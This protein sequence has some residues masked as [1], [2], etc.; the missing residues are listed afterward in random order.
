MNIQE[1]LAYLRQTVARID[2]KYAG[3]PAVSAKP[4]VF[5]EELLS[6]EVIETPH[7][8]HFETEK[9]YPNHQRHGSYEISDLIGLQPDL[10]EALSDG[11]ITNAH[12]KR[13]AFLDTETTGLAGGSGTY[14]FLIGLG[15]IDEEGFRV[16][17]FFM[18]DYAEEASVLHSLAA[19]LARFDVL[20][21]YNG[22]SYDQ[23]LLETRYTMCRA[24]HPFA[25][26]E[27]LDLLYGARRLFKL[28]LESCRL[29]NLENQI[30]GVERTGDIPGEMIPY[31]FFE[32][33]RT[34][35]AHRLMPVF[36]HNV[37]DI[38]SLACL[39]GIIPEAFRDPANMRARHGMDLLGLARWLELSGRREEALNLMR[40]AIDMG[41]PDAQLFRTLFEAG[42]IEKKLG[43]EF[44][45]VATFTDLSL[46]PNA[47]RVKAYEELAKHYEH[48]ER[49]F[50]MAIECV[51]AARC[52]EDSEALASRQSRLEKKSAPLMRQPRL[53]LAL[54][55]AKRA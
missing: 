38:V 10:L 50:S 19:Y 52:L 35:R 45:A 39:T 36:H 44:A 13:W 34:R 17:Q 41:L 6:G 4:G 15:S 53:G 42:S 7:G 33:L 23:P 29:V 21:T 25:R 3:A 48:R 27:H 22:R 11:A 20:I 40:R 9:L 51:R 18:R 2:G 43:L 55:T 31:V 12:P 8:R 46:S 1:Q 54:K 26:M 24:R 14:A 5:V 16:R 32:Y 47:Y 37:L 28:R 49:N 30:L